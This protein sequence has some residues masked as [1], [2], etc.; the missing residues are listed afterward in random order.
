[1][2]RAVP[3]RHHIDTGK[4][5]YVHDDGSIYQ[6]GGCRV[7]RSCLDCP[8]AQCVLDQP[9]RDGTEGRKARRLAI[10]QAITEEG[11]SIEAAAV[12]FGVTERT[13]FR[14]LKAVK[15]GIQTQLPGN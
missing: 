7:S 8:L 9:K 12:K 13:I 4:G 5:H 1:M 2:S 14:A 6:D 10:Y 3:K 15:D 11:L